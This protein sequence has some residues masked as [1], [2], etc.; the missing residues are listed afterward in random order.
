MCQY[1]RN[2]QETVGRTRDRRWG[3]IVKAQMLM[4]SDPTHDRPVQSMVGPMHH[5]SDHRLTHK[6]YSPKIIQTWSKKKRKKSTKPLKN[7]QQMYLRVLK[8]TRKHRY[9]AKEHVR[10][11]GEEMGRTGVPGALRGAGRQ[12][13]KFRG[14]AGALWLARRARA[15]SSEELL[16]RSDRRGTPSPCPGEL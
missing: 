12:P 16:W 5:R 8:S 13:S 11:G 3:S 2:H 7:K 4:V 6:P 10:K 15:Q 1:Q 9:I 14:L